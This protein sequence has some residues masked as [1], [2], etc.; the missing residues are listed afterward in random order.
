[1]AVVVVVVNDDYFI[2]LLFQRKDVLNKNG[3]HKI[4]NKWQLYKSF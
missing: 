2:T 3:I 4:L 1:M